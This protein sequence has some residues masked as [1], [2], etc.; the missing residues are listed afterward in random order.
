V[1]WSCGEDDAATTIGGHHGASLAFGSDGKLYIS[2]GDNGQPSDSQLLTSYHGKMLRINPDGTTPSNNPFVD[3]PGGNKDEIWAYGLRN[4]YRMTFDPASGRLYVGDVGGNVHATAVEEINLV[5]PGSN[6]GW[7]RCEG[8]CNSSGVSS[9]VYSYPHAGRDAAIMGGFFYSGT[10]FPAGFRGSYFFADYTQN[11]LKRITFDATGTVVTGVFNVQP[12][13]GT[14][15]NT[16]VGDP[17]QLQQGPDGALYYLDLSFDE[18]V[19]CFNAGRLRRV[20]FLGTANQPPVVVATANPLE[21]LAPLQ[22]GF[23]S[24]GTV[25]P[26]GG[27]TLLF[28]GLR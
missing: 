24:D 26:E 14:P 3:G 17:V 27:F 25:D 22:V 19:G 16:Q 8:P 21:G 28:V 1:R 23:S 7:P 2:T 15:D 11:W 9:P 4:P 5:V 18:R 10:Q 6:Y 20:Q 12:L 13:D